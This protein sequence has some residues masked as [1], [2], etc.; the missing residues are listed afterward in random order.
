[1]TKD[2]VNDQHLASM[3]L[4]GARLGETYVEEK[5][6]ADRFQIQPD[7]DRCQS[8]H[9]NNLQTRCVLKDGHSTRHVRGSLRWTDQPH[10]LGT[11]DFSDVKDVYSFLDSAWPKYGGRHEILMNQAQALVDYMG[12]GG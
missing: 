1:M 11:I 12:Q 3:G 10:P 8:H 9:P 2:E 4:S 7:P 5:F 6:K